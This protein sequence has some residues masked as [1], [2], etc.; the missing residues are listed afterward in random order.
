L[1]LLLTANFKINRWQGIDILPGQLVTGRKA[2][3]KELKLSEREI[4][5]SLTKLKTTSEIAIKTTNKFSIITICKWEDY[6][7][8]KSTERPAERPATGPASDQ[9]TTTLKEGKERKEVKK[10]IYREFAHLKITV[11]EFNKLIEAGYSKEQ[12]DGKLDDIENWKKNKNYSDLYKTVNNWLK[13]DYPEV[14]S[15]Q[16]KTGINKPSE[17]DFDSLTA[18]RL[19]AIHQPN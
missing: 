7:D 2:L 6:Q 13:K 16:A 9:Q 15:K 19:N 18:Q 1:H 14:V 4:R 10:D 17:F 12:I 8:T 11:F 3:A 5:T